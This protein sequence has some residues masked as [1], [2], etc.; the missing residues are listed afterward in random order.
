MSTVEI[1][2]DRAQKQRAEAEHQRKIEAAFHPNSEALNWQD[3]WKESKERA[4]EHLTWPDV[5]SGWLCS[6]GDGFWA[7]SPG[8]DHCASTQRG[9]L[10]IFGAEAAAAAGLKTGRGYSKWGIHDHRN[11]PSGDP[12]VAKDLLKGLGCWVEPEVADESDQP[13]SKPKR[14]ET[15]VPHDDDLY[16]APPLRLII[17]RSSPIASY[18]AEIV[19]ALHTQREDREPLIIVDESYRPDTLIEFLK[20]TKLRTLIAVRTN[21]AAH[22]LCDQLQKEFDLPENRHLT[23]RVDIWDGRR[24]ADKDDLKQNCKND[25]APKAQKLGLPI[26]RSLCN[27]CPM[28]SSCDLM[29]QREFAIKADHL[30]VTE[31]ALAFAGLNAFSHRDRII[32]LDDPVGVLRPVTETGSIKAVVDAVWSACELLGDNPAFNRGDMPGEISI[33]SGLVSS[34][35]TDGYSDQTHANRAQTFERWR[36]R[37]LFRFIWSVIAYCRPRYSLRVINTIGESPTYAMSWLF[38]IM[39]QAGVVLPKDANVGAL[40]MASE[41]DALASFSSG[42]LS[43]W[44]ENSPHDVPIVALVSELPNHLPVEYEVVEPE[45]PLRNPSEAVQ[46]VLP[47]NRKDSNQ[48][49]CSALRAVLSEHGATRA[50]VV[51]HRD[52][53]SN[54]EG[55]E[56][57]RVSMVL[58]FHGA[59]VATFRSADLVVCLGTPQV[60]DKEVLL[61]FR[62]NGLDVPANMKFG[63]HIMGLE[64]AVGGFVDTEIMAHENPDAMAAHASLIRRKLGSVLAFGNPQVVVVSSQFTGLPLAAS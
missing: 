25:A 3:A 57:S 1:E 45:A 47:L 31:A 58:S 30:I 60:N 19:E 48:R 29:I 6:V 40:L 10:W 51:T 26:G 28:R 16:K 2:R 46:H 49:Y 13:R 56:D 12:A 38:Q 43:V 14:R 34:Q 11:N 9:G 33:D 59:S 5:L 37:I 62:R 54:I 15:R 17:D 4:E 50:V 8:D 24:M 42:T 52:K 22:A 20:I 35:L 18:R 44:K 41:H 61:E 63:P 32:T 55:M 39:D 64:V 21:D 27:V 23:I 36:I 53:I 7:R